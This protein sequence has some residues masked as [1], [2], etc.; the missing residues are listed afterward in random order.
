MRKPK[1][2]ECRFIQDLQAINNIDILWHPIAPSPYPLLTS[3]PTEGKFFIVTDVRSALLSI[4]VDKA[5]QSLL[6]FTWEGKQFIWT[7]IPQSSTESSCYFSQ[8]PKADLDDMKFPRGSTLF[9]YVNDFP[10]S[11]S[12]QVSSQK[13]SIHL[14]KLLAFKGH[15]VPL[16]KM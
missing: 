10:L 11:S 6:A 5:S 13:D 16:E 8:I 14:L 7:I 15:Q 12:F 1:G 3:I 2:Q 4:P 9:Q